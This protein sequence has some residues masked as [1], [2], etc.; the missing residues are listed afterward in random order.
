MAFTRYCEQQ[1]VV[2]PQDY[3]LSVGSVESV[4][5]YAETPQHYP[6]IGPAQLQHQIYRVG[7]S[8]ESTLID[9]QPVQFLVDHNHF[10]MVGEL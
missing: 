1:S 6:L 9:K 8:A 7:I 2:L 3:R 10:H 5:F 4:T